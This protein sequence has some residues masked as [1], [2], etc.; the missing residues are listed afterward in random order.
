MI[1]VWDFEST[2]LVEPKATQLGKCR[3]S[4]DLKLI[5]S[6]CVSYYINP[7]KEISWGAMG[8]TGITNE[9]V[10]DKPLIEEVLANKKSKVHPDTEYIVCHNMTYDQQ[11]FPEGF[12]PKGV[13]FLCTLKLARKLIDKGLCGDHKNTTLYY[14]LECYKKPF[15][16]EFIEKS[17]DG[18]SDSMMTANVLVTMLNKANL[19]IEEA[20]Q[21]TQPDITV[22]QFPKYRGLKW[23]E[24]IE[25]DSSYVEWL[26]GNVDWQDEKEFL[27]VKDLFDNQ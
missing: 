20:Y 11:F 24:A 12:V 16:K 21:L 26:L 5:K 17:H 8:V 18:L 14:F 4:K 3:L 7:E 2:G 25:K 10:A 27:Y 22:C 19:T 9:M 13:K 23:S 15:G 6:S 1:E